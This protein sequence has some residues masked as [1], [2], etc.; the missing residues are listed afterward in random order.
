LVLPVVGVGAAL[1]GLYLGA[2]STAGWW[3]VGAGVAL[4]IADMAIDWLWAH[5][6]GSKSD[7]PGLN[8]RGTELVGQI[9]TVVEA[10]EPDARGK[11]TAADTVWAA[12]GCR[13]AAGTRVRV[14]GVKGTVLTVKAI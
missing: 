1:F 13:A 10:I 11:V 8:R 3:W 4:I 14:T 12:E 7:E 5:S 2:R 6:S 9:V